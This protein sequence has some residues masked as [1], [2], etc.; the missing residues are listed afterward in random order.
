MESDRLQ[1]ADL[2]FGIC[3][4]WQ[5]VARSG[6]VCTGRCSSGPGETRG[7]VTD[8]HRRSTRTSNRD[9]RRS[10]PDPH[11]RRSDAL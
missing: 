1:A 10:A 4:R 3:S 9:G 5:D 11:I 7:Y 8:E 6:L 2:R